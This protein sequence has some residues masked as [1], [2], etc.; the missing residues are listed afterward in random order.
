[1]RN[2]EKDSPSV[3]TN[4]IEAILAFPKHRFQHIEKGILHYMVF[5]SNIPITD[6]YDEL[7]YRIPYPLL[8]DVDDFIGNTKDINPRR[9]EF[10]YEWLVWDKENQEIKSR[11]K[12][13]LLDIVIE[14]FN[15]E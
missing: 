8:K 14:C 4:P 10:Y 2:K 15:F 3:F 9:N 1:M 7:E 12:V 6:G 13:Y 5:D 11:E